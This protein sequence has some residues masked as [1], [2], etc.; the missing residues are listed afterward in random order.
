MLLAV[1][2]VTALDKVLELPGTEAAVRVA[3]L[4]GPQEIGS[5]LEVGTDREDL[6]DKVLHAYNA[7]LAEALLN[8]GVVGEGNALLV[9]LPVSTLVNKLF[10]ALEIRVAISNPRLDHLDHFGS[11]LRHLDKN[12]IVDLQKTK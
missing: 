5:L 9:D 2:K 8:D 10:D 12:A 6:M 1:A 11:R 4:E 7:K 3:Q